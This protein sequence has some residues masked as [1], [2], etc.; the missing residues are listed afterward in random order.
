MRNKNRP[1]LLGIGSFALVTMIL[2]SF[3]VFHARDSH[4]ANAS[5]NQ[6]ARQLTS[7]GITS[8][9]T[10]PFGAPKLQQPEISSAVQGLGHASVRPNAGVNRSNAHSSS[11][12]A[13]AN[14]ATSAT[15]NAELEKSFNGLNFFQ[16]RYANNGNQYS[17]EPPDQGLCVGNGYVMESVNDVLNV[18]NTNG[19]SLLGVVALNTFYD[20]QPA[21]V[22]SNP[23]VFGPF[24]TDPSCYFDKPTQRWF[25]IVLTI[26]VDPS[27]GAFLGS[28][29]LDIA[30]TQTASPLGEWTIYR[31]PVQDDGT[32]G[33]PNHMCAGG[34]CLG[35]YP[36]LGADANAF[37]ITTNEYPFFGA[38]F[39]AAQIYA[40]SKAE[41][42]AS[43]HRVTFVQFDTI[44]TVRRNTNPGF[45]IWP[46]IT[47]DHQYDSSRGGT[48]YF[49]SSDAAPEANGT[50]NSTDLITWS[51]SNTSSLNSSAP[52]LTLSNTTLKVK[53]YVVPPKSYQKPGNHP[54]GE[55]LNHTSCSTLLIGGR[56]PYHEFLPRLDSNDTRMQQVTYANGLLWGS[57]DTSLTVS[58]NNE[59]GIEWFVVKPSVSSTGVSAHLVNNG[60]LGLA[61]TNLTYPAI[62]VTTNGQGV[63]AFTL[64]GPN[65]FPSAAY[66]L[67]NASGVGAVHIAA[68][69]L[70]PDDGFSGYIVFNGGANPP[71]TR[72]GDYGAAVADGNSIWIASEYI[73]QTCTLQQ[74]LTNTPSS[75]L[76][77]CGMT[78]AA[79]G[80]W[81]TRI[82]QVELA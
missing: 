40:F 14:S 26:D 67:I 47:P 35:D 64:V 6:T 22:R 39:H 5:S 7:A 37:F 55:C 77:T 51:V 53:Q 60:Y 30:V 3:F 45:T 50:G 65:N 74:Y 34:P 79:L 66:A 9:K 8:F 56:D 13:S 57:L 44:N 16:Q 33:T 49:L 78:R 63:M 72:W 19:K 28:N 43:A 41:L 52:A 80:N 17:V 24:V 23:P 31:L 36:H 1:L 20:Y 2:S 54:L 11:Q 62:G 12:G 32:M 46:A 38:G 70:G 48:E 10:A 73:G 58:G 76:F 15:S 4:A 71:R 59:A 75:P 81:Y 21:I 69:G 42:A 25:Q 82:S 61:N 18:Y 68:A 29:H 27:T